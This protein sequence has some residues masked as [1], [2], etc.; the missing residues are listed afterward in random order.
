MKAYSVDLRAKIVG[1]HKRAEAVDQKKAEI[2]ACSKSSFQKL[3]KQQKIEENLQ[4]K[5]GVNPDSVI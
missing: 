5:L 4:S 2:F 1:A 3:V